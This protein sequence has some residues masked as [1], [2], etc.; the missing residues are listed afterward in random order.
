M[1]GLSVHDSPV[2]GLIDGASATVP[3]K[4]F[5]GATVIVD[6][7]DRPAFAFVEVGLAETAKSCTVKVTIDV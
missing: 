2:D 3:V 6:V 1:V 7:A 5:T 4:P